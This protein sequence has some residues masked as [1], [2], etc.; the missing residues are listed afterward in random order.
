[1]SGGLRDRLP[2]DHEG[3]LEML[4]GPRGIVDA[5]VPGAVFAAAYS[6]S[7]R[8]LGVS[9][10]WAVGSA[11]V[12]FVL[13]LL[14]RRSLQ[15]AVVG[16]LGI[17]AMAAFSALTGQ[18][19]NFFLPSVLKNAGY[20]LAYLVSVLVRWPLLG[21]LLGPL[22]GEGFAW[23]NDPKRM[24][25]YSLASLVWAAMFGIRVLVQLPLYLAGQVEALGVVAIPL[26]LPL[27][28]PTLW[29]TFAILRRT[30]PT[31]QHPATE[32]EAPG[33]APGLQ[34]GLP[35]AIPDAD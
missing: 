32:P 15:Q 18:A 2:S 33:T 28:V 6:L 30:P 24:R 17:A 9:L 3:L 22:F 20:A 31:R 12:L 34:P 29:I 11:V 13:A 23:R 26:G 10:A 8:Q 16:L 25:A 27:F 1:V 35:P 14:Q 4:G 21:V 5:G 7:G 19:K